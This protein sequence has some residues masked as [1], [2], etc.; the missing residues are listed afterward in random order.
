MPNFRALLEHEKVFKLLNQTAEVLNVRAYL[1]GGFVRDLLLKRPCKD[2]D[3]VCVGSG[4]E[5]ANTFVTLTRETLKVTKYKNFGTARVNYEDYILEFVGARKESYRNHS[6]NPEVVP[7]TFQ[8][9]QRR[10]DFTIN[11]LSISLNAADLGEL[12]DPFNG[13]TDLQTKTLKTPLD[14]HLTFNDD[15][16]RMLRAIRFATQLNFNINPET[17]KAIK[18]NRDRLKIIAPER[19]RDELNK[20]ILSPKP[21]YGFKLLLAT[22]I[23]DL[24]FPEL[25]ALKGVEIID[26]KRH[27]DNFYHTLQVLDNIAPMTTDL[28]L[29]WAALLHD[30]AKPATKRFQPTIGW[31]FHG[32]EDL[33][34]R[35]V[36]SI[37]RRFRLP[38]NHKMRFVQKMVAMH[39]RPIVLAQSEV[40]ESAIRRLVVD[41]GD[42]LEALFKLCRADITSKNPAK[43]KQ[44]SHNFDLVEAKI[45]QVEQKDKLRN[46]QPPITGETIMVTFNLKPS[47]TV[48]EVKIK[49]RQAILDGLIPNDYQ[50]CFEYMLEVGK[51]MGLNA[52]RPN[53]SDL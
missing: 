49:I 34:S 24:I 32:H 12:S 7:G 36:P 22:Q 42:D 29:R 47:K 30:I 4:I 1:I 46:F 33:G 52:K 19:S 26:H 48:G 16:L 10:R 20:I 38:R 11:T 9:D 45:K 50:A 14:A 43:V 27:K 5:F 31:T 25:V 39:L 6:R 17:F 44:Y 51:V 3:I 53:F 28:Y 23:L 35:M 21:S 8:D 2:I 40:T 41:A 13:L 18:D 37:F 15:P